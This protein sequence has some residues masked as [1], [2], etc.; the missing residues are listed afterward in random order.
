[1][2]QAA[3]RLWAAF[4]FCLEKHHKG[5]GGALRHTVLSDLGIPLEKWLWSGYYTPAKRSQGFLASGSRIPRSEKYAFMLPALGITHEWNNVERSDRT[6]GVSHLHQ[7]LWACQ[8]MEG[9]E[10]QGSCQARI[11][12]SKVRDALQIYLIFTFFNSSF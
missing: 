1:M 2:G 3:L 6:R 12:A 11:R 4:C 7:Q 10:E 9:G 8:G 5:G